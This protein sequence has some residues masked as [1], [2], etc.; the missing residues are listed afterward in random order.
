MNTAFK[1]SFAGF[2]ILAALLAPLRLHA[3][4]S[5]SPS[6][7]TAAQNGSQTQG[8][9]QDKRGRILLDQMVT[10]LGGEAWLNRRDMSQVGHSSQFFHGAPNGNNVEFHAEHRFPTASLTEADRVGFLVERG[11]IMPGKKIDV[12]QV[13]TNDNGYEV[14]FKGRT[15]LPKDQVE[16]YF[17]RRAHSIENVI[18]VWIKAPGVMIVYGGSSMVERRQTDQISILSANNDAVTIDLDATTHLPLRR[19]FQ[20][21]NT[22]FKDHD[23]DAEEYDAYHT[24]QGLPTPFTISRYHNGDLAAQRFFTK[25]EYNTNLGPEL[26]NPDNLLKKK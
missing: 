4:A 18:R 23:E 3:Q 12:V 22:T 16:D 14:T 11:M 21:R 2:A 19:T 10:A 1:S 15:S 26:F 17:R 24:I 8:V 13:W 9:E 25:V 7:Q 5:D 20:W 6:A